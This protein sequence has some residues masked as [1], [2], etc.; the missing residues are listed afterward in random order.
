MELFPFQE[1]AVRTLSDKFFKS[2]KQTTV[3]YAP[4]GAG[5]TIMLI[6][7]MDNVIEL[8]PHTYDYVFVWLTPGNGELEEQSW[9]RAKDYGKLVRA[10]NLDEALTAGFQAN[11]ATFLNWERVKNDKAIALRE[12][13]TKNLDDIIADARSKGHRFVLIIDEEH[14][15][16]TE[17]AQKIIDKFKADKIIRA[18]ATPKSDSPSYDIV[19]VNDE[20]VIA[21]GL[22]VRNVE[23]NP[24]GTDGDIVANMVQ[25]FLDQADDKRRQIK[26]EYQRLGLNINPLVLIQFPDAKRANKEERDDLIKQVRNY[27]REIGQDDSEVATWLANE[28]LNIANIEKTDSPVNYL[29]MKQAV[30]TGWDAPRAKILV[31]LRLNTDPNFT[32]QTIGRIRRM[33]ER[34][35]YDNP[36]LDNAFIYSNDQK[37]IAEVLSKG[38]ASYIATYDVN[39]DTPDFGLTSVKPN[40][41][42]GLTNSE[43]VAGLRNQFKKDYGLVE[44]NSKQNQ[45]KLESF[46]FIFGTFINQKLQRSDDLA[47]DI[48]S[49]KLQSFGLSIPVDTQSHSLELLNVQQKIQPLLQRERPAD[50]SAILIELFSNRSESPTKRFLN[51]KPRELMAFTINNYRLIRDTAKRAD[52]DHKFDK[53]LSLE[54]GITHGELELVK[55]NAPKNEMYQ[56]FKDSQ[57]EVFT[58][59]IYKGYGKSNWVKTSKPEQAFETWLENE[60]K[61]AWWYR[62]KD[63]GEK[64]FSIA[65]GQKREGFFPDYIFLGIDGLTYVVETKG[66]QNENIDAY[67][68]AKFKALREWAENKDAN[69]NGAKFAFVRPLKNHQGDITG[70]LFNNTHW[71]DDLNNRQVWR[72]I[73]EIFSNDIF[74]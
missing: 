30:S 50:I 43:V 1:Q 44:Q 8:N 64:Y 7:F 38:E 33:P 74:H 61:V 31:K 26:A 15:D 69:P 19:Q 2:D 5:K 57:D 3:F 17:K 18:S 29:L 35:H 20:D 71:D 63:R 24:D 11:T 42:T 72:P 56:R 10:I 14:R 62:S 59:N 45:E 34:K 47:R 6:N 58:K 23:L 46:G 27:L 13:E 36:L 25:Y 32:L 54:F 67:S 37:Y 16:Q 21:A 51:L 60:D 48:I 52:A 9:N 39:E 73:S 4:T 70:L 41:H 53:Q 55:F 68:E 65:Y 66:G 28:K 40:A 12:G 49:D 22:I